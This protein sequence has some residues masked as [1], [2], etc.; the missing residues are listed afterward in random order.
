MGSLRVSGIHLGRTC[1]YSNPKS[2]LGK[3]EHI[4]ETSNRRFRDSEF[5][6]PRA[7][8]Q[9][10]KSIWIRIKFTPVN[11]PLYP[12]EPLGERAWSEMQYTA[13]SFVVPKFSR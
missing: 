9:G 10:K 11:R 4:V 8:T 6:V 1:V 5:L 12:G 3:T 2:E 13:Y 7:L